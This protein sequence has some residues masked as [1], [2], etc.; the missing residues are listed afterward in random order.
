MNSIAASFLYRT[1][2]PEE[3]SRH[4]YQD[5]KTITLEQYL[6][7]EYVK[8]D[9][10]ERQLRLGMLSQY[11]E[12]YYPVTERYLHEADTIEKTNDTKDNKESKRQSEFAETKDNETKPDKKIK[13]ELK[14][15]VENI[16][17]HTFFPFFQTE[18]AV[19]LHVHG[20]HQV[21]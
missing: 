11:A 6:L 2:G 10:Y 21:V 19:Q 13:P 20:N 3:W 16:I 17:T 14:Q 12:P 5:Q 7:Y 8:T 1:I 4:Q 18:P 9:L 15:V